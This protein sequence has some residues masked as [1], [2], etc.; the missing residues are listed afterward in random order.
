MYYLM[1]GWLLS[2]VLKIKRGLGEGSLRSLR[3]I[4]KKEGKIY[5]KRGFGGEAPRFF[6]RKNTK[7]K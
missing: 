5:K 4:V 3:Q 1:I 7:Y 2:S 6:F